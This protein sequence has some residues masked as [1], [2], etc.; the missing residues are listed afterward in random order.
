MLSN[1]RGIIFH[2]R[3][4]GETS[5]IADIFTEAHGLRGFI[6]G[7]VRTPKAR[8][9]YGLFQPMT[10]VDLVC[11]FRDSPH[12]LNRLKEMRAAIT[13]Q[14]IPF[15]VRR[16]A[17][18][19]FM[20]EVCRKTIHEG[21]ENTPL[22]GFLVEYLCWLDQT[23]HPLANLHLH[24]MLHLSAHLGFQLE[25]REERPVYFD[26]QEGLFYSHLPPL[27]SRTLLNEHD[28]ARLCTLLECPLTRCH[29]VSMSRADRRSLLQGML[30]FYRSR[31]PAFY[32]IHTPEILEM[33]LG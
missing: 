26:W 29:E 31:L 18:A 8:I 3:P 13:F 2:A 20:A 27:E 1:T 7:S 25:P 17:I 19:L 12:H 11:Y 30:N 33:V 4:Y 9:P 23:E 5:V 6:A 15:E 14:R 32:T 22:F 24:F 10:V 28:S 16:G 21:E